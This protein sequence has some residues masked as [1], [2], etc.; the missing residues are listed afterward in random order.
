[1]LLAKIILK[2]VTDKNLEIMKNTKTNESEIITVDKST[3]KEPVTIRFKKLS[4]GKESIYLDIYFN[5]SRNYEF[6][7]LYLDPYLKPNDNREI[8]RKAQIIKTRYINEINFEQFQIPNK[9]KKRI[10]FLD[11]FKKFADEPKQLNYRKVRNNVFKHLEMHFKSNTALWDLRKKN[12]V[13][14]FEYLETAK[15]LYTRNGVTK[16]TDKEISVNTK[17]SYIT[18]LS[19]FF[20]KMMEKEKIKANPMLTVSRNNFKREDA[21]I[22]YLTQSEVTA[23]INNQTNINKEIADAFLFAIYTGLRGIEVSYIKGENVIY[24]NGSTFLKYKISKTGAEQTLKLTN[25]AIALFPQDYKKSDNLFKL[26]NYS[27]T[28]VGKYLDRW[29]KQCGIDKKIT[30]HCS[31]HTNATLLLTNNIDLK[32]VSKMLGHKSISM[33]E[34]YATVIQDRKDEASDVMD[35]LF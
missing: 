27:K 17:A 3:G 1:M 32:V 28:T 6:L 2:F 7:K 8:Y 20:K 34:R 24:K 23:L 5:G 4:G 15:G 33:T 16:I 29:M 18:I 10:L 13:D 25:S 21:N 9:D 22:N 30:F 19:V 31:R 11:E 35:K 12:I 14:F 26:G